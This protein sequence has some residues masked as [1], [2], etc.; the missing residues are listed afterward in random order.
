[1]QKL[2][3]MLLSGLLFGGQAYAWH[4]V[5]H[6]Y[7]ASVA[8][9]GMSPALQQRAADILRVHPR[10]DEDFTARM[11]GEV[12]SG[13]RQQQD[14]WLFE[15]AATWPDIAQQAPEN[16]RSHYH[17]SRWHYINLEVWLEDEAGN[18]DRHEVALDV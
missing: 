8:W 5:G 14:Q 9:S 6:R 18:L 11:P 1:M 10:F 13:S 17:R 16:V 7:T 3:V 15:H 12:R 4:D 2:F